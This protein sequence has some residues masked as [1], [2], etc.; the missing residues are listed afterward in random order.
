VGY[1]RED[2]AG[3]GLIWRDLTPP[4]W[5]ER[6]QRLIPE[7]SKSGTLQPF[8]K[9]Y[10]RKDGSRV[11]VLVGV[12][13]FQENG[14]EGVA[15]V[16]DLTERK[17]QEREIS[18]LNERLITA[19]E[20]ERIGLAAELHDGVMQDLLA[21]TMLLGSAKRRI[22]EVPTRE[23]KSTPFRNGSFARAQTSAASLMTCTHRSCMRGGCPTRCKTSAKN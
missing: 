16:V 7:L 3:G 17:Q 13:A 6:D 22:P 20:Q 12:A 15:F 10:F 2:L 23:P 8:E 14:N 4:E 19:Q 1:D 11:P 9:E 21:I 5:R 18:A